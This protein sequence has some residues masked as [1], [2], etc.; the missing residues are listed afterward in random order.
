MQRSRSLRT[1]ALFAISFLTFVV[2]G[3]SVV[4]AGGD[5]VLRG[6][7]STAVPDELSYERDASLAPSADA[8][9]RYERGLSNTVHRMGQ[10][11]DYD[12]AVYMRNH[13]AAAGWNAK[14]VTYVVPIAWPTQQRLEVTAPSAH[15]VDL[16]EPSVPGDRWSFDHNAIGKPYSG[17]SSDGDVKR[18]RT[19]SKDAGQ[20][21][22]RY[23]PRPDGR[24]GRRRERATPPK[25]GRTSTAHLSRAGLRPILPAVPCE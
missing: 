14:I 12:T 8:A 25:V 2:L 16:Y 19:S 17:Y 22:R 20:R 23:R 11:T 3:R 7:P 13:L 24:G 6:Y 18:Y 4:V 15:D 21:Q 1:L 5:A 9:M 10:T